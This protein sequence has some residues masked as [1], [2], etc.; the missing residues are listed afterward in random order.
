M[1]KTLMVLSFFFLLVML[2]GCGD[3]KLPN[4][5][6]KT[7][8]E[9]KKIFDKK[10]NLTVNYEYVFD[11]DSST[12]TTFLEYRGNLK[13]GDKIKSGDEVTIAFNFKVIK[14]PNL[15]G[16]TKPE[17]D[18]YFLDKGIP[19][20]KITFSARLNDDVEIGTFI[21]YQNLEVG[22]AVDLS[23][24][25]LRIY[26]EARIKLPDLEGLNKY[27]ITAFFDSLFINLDEFEYMNDNSK[28]FDTFLAYA[29]HDVGDVVTRDDLIKIFLYSNTDVS[30]GEYIG[31]AEQLFISKYVYSSTEGR[32]I[33]LYNP[34]AN[35]INLSD[36]Y[37]AILSG[38]VTPSKTINL[39]GS[40]ESKQTY[41]ITHPNSSSSYLQKASLI[42]EEFDITIIDAIQLRK[43]SNNTYIDTIYDIGNISN[44]LDGEI[45]VRRNGITHGRRD[46]TIKEWMGFIPSYSTVIGT[47]P[48]SG[49]VDPPFELIADLTFK[50]F[51]MTKVK[52]LYAADGDTVY[53]Q[54]LDPRDQ[55]SYSG[56]HRVRFLIVDT[57]ETEKPGQV[58]EPYAQAA[59]TFTENMLSNAAEIYLQ[60]SLEGGLTDT[61]GRHL[62]LIWANVGTIANP[63]WKLLNYELLKWGLGRMYIAKSGNYFNHP[64]FGGRYL[65][66]WAADAEDYARDNKIGVHSGV[67]QP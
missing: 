12:E 5:D 47:H 46:F 15:T 64:I 58:G 6:G 36:Y 56:D 2:L 60:S 45:F 14:L 57:P 20:A 29:T 31:E 22:D 18:Q 49:P 37:I 66:Q 44:V 41:V 1:K 23:V 62:G 50:N 42:S 13:A 51:G 9:V 24:D 3:N 27:Q 25:N 4:L 17:M 35:A 59:K 39:T 34:T 40:L 61:Y 65:Y 55:T 52:Y 28:E 53:F 16:Y 38:G 32:L 8:T 30:Y 48:Y 21:S 33:E 54:S 7:E 67:F 19:L 11:P 10:S 43:T 26:Y 63:E